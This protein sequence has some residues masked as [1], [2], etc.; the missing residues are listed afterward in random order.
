MDSWLEP[1]VTR[2]EPANFRL[3]PANFRLEPADPRL[4]PADPR[5]EPADCY[6]ALPIGP[7]PSFSAKPADG[8]ERCCHRVIARPHSIYLM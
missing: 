5:L 2:L 1:G 3:E 7:E 8:N 6:A 4:E